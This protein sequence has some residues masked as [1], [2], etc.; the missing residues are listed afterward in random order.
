MPGYCRVWSSTSAGIS[1][2]LM[3]PAASREDS[4]MNARA[5]PWVGIPCSS[6]PTARSPGPRGRDEVDTEEDLTFVLLVPDD[7]E[8]GDA[9]PK[10]VGGNGD[11]TQYACQL[12]THSPH[13]LLVGPL[14]AGLGAV[15]QDDEAT[16][17]ENQHG[18]QAGWSKSVWERPGSKE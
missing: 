6:R 12:A 5:G 13:H 11:L 10:G 17:D 9:G 1:N 15:G 14:I 4:Q 18:L 3:G 2:C 8:E 16:D 7:D